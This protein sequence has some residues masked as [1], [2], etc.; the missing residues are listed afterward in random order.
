VQLAGHMPALSRRRVGI[1]PVS[2]FPGRANIHRECILGA[3]RLTAT[4]ADVRSTSR[5]W[6]LLPPRV[7][8]SIKPPGTEL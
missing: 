3:F 2:D 5:A 8:T 1:T 6:Y 4:D 7:A